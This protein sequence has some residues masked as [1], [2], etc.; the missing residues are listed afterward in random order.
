MTASR[1]RPLTT[2]REDWGRITLLGVTWLALPLTL[3]PLAQQRIVSSLAGM[4]NGSTPLFVAA[5]ATILLRRPPGSRHRVGLGIGVVGLFLVAL[6]SL[7]K[8]STSAVGVVL[9]VAAVSS[10]G[11]AFNIA[12]PLQQRYGMLPVLWRAQAVALLLTTPRMIAGL[13]S[14]RFD[15]QGAWAAMIALGVLGTGLGYVATGTLSGRVGS[16][17]ASVITYLATPVAMVFGLVFRGDSLAPLS[18][19]GAALTLA[20]AWITSRAER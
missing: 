19:A 9:V 7:G 13:R 15:R 4:I 2:E 16:T 3:F 10:Y 17:R 6:P 11:V 5:I 8:G 14:S 1:A 18:L 12:A 20:G